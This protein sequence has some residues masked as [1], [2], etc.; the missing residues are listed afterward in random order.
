MQLFH[1]KFGVPFEGGSRIILHSPSPF[2]TSLKHSNRK[3]KTSNCYN[4]GKKMI[5]FLYKFYI[6]LLSSKQK[7]GE[8]GNAYILTQNSEI[9]KA[10][11]LCTPASQELKVWRNPLSSLVV[12]LTAA[13]LPRSG[14]LCYRKE[15]AWLGPVPPE[16]SVTHS[17]LAI[18]ELQRRAG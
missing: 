13:S 7:G 8:K 10:V 5:I 9:C 12:S 15:A 4:N 18:P 3:N 1:C 14:T 16:R 6:Q 2:P 11:P 17:L